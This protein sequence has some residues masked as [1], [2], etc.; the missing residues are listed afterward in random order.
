M[1]WHHVTLQLGDLL[2]KVPFTLFGAMVLAEL[3]QSVRDLSPNIARFAEA[4]FLHPVLSSQAVK[5][6]SLIRIDGS[7]E[8]KVFNAQSIKLC[9]PLTWRLELLEGIV[10]PLGGGPRQALTVEPREVLEPPVS[11]QPPVSGPPVSWNRDHGPT[12]GCTTCDNINAGRRVGSAGCRRYAQ[13][14]RETLS[15]EGVGIRPDGPALPSQALPAD[16]DVASEE[17][18]G[19]D[20]VVNEILQLLDADGERHLLE[21]YNTVWR[22]RT[23]PQDWSHAIVVSIYKGKGDDSDPASYRP[24]SLL[25]VTYKVCAAM[26]QARLAGAFD[27]RLRPQQFGFRADRGTRHPLFVVRRAMEWSTMT[28]RNL[29]LL[30]LDWKQASLTTPPCYMRWN[31]LVSHTKC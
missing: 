14:L 25:N 9:V 29:Q 18:P 19:P 11:L 23:T 22:N 4:A 12:A 28:N 20:G 6:C 5:V 7:M 8:L 16:H 10:S 13:W 24:I 21:F 27:D 17:Q 26:L 2:R 3:P 1:T 15:S 31:A 30:F